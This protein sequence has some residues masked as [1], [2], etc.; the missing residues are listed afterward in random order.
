MTEG[1]VVNR[2]SEEQSGIGGLA[3]VAVIVLLPVLYV[4]SIGLVVVILNK[5]ATPTP[6]HS[7]IKQQAQFA[8]SA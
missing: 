5:S 4:L 2:E 6:S 1:S 3:W 7:Y 8:M